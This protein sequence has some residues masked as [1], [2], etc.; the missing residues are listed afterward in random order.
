MRVRFAHR[1]AESEFQRRSLDAHVT[2]ERD[3]ITRY[4]TGRRHQFDPD[5][6]FAKAT[7]DRR[8]PHLAVGLH[9]FGDTGGIFRT[10]IGTKIDAGRA[11]P[12]VR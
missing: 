12:D 9:E 3:D 8:R 6:L 1:Q 11:G 7:D 4:Q 2:G 10:H 5:Q